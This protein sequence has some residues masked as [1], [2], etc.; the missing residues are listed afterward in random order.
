MSNGTPTLLDVRRGD[1]LYR[2][3][4]DSSIE[5]HGSVPIQKGHSSTR[6]REYSAFHIYSRENMYPATKIYGHDQEFCQDL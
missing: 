4:A 5:H 2:L 6:L 3:C 1:P